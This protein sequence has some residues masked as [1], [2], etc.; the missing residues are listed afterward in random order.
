MLARLHQRA[1]LGTSA[2]LTAGVLAADAVKLV[3]GWSA[4]G[5]LG[6]LL[7]A[8]LLHQLGFHTA[9]EHTRR[10]SRRLLAGVAALSLVVLVA[11]LSLPGF[12][13]DTTG[14]PGEANTGPH[15]PTACLLLL[16]VAQVCLVLAV[17]GRLVG[18]LGRHRPW[19]LITLVRAVPMTSYLA[20]LI[21]LTLVLGLFGVLGDGGQPGRL[22]WLAALTLLALPL[23]VALRDFERHQHGLRQAGGPGHHLTAAGRGDRH[24]QLAI[25]LGAFYGTLGVLGFV[26]TGFAGSATLVVLPVDPLQNIIHVLLGWYLVHVAHAGARHPR[27]V[28]LLTAFACLP[29]LL[30][31]DPAEAVAPAVVLL[32]GGTIAVALTAVLVSSRGRAPRALTRPGPPIRTR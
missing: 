11:L 17:R 14:L 15:P 31:F 1:R 32:H 9:T 24:G 4:A 21:G 12:P 25:V 26:V 7:A 18:W 3:T 8:L 30:A 27:L 23:L 5:Y 10:P 22:L 6:V 20:Y 16:G 29:P 28:W 19:Q 13:R 2:A